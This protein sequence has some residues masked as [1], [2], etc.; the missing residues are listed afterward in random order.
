MSYIRYYEEHP[1]AERYLYQNFPQHFVWKRTRRWE[2]RQ[3]GFAIGRLPYCS[4]SCGERFYL[5][6]LLVNVAGSKSFDDLKTVNGHLCTTFKQ[7]CI[8]LHLVQDDREWMHCFEE[9]ERFATG[10]CEY[11]QYLYMIQF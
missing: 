8:E 10:K 3:R 5:R 4:P 6:L 1:N 7:A 11:I 9:A 2:P